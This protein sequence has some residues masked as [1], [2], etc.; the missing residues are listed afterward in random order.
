MVNIGKENCSD[1]ELTQNFCFSFINIL[2]SF[3]LLHVIRKTNH[4]H[5][6]NSAKKSFWYEL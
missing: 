2:R 4:D 5:D 6:D 1:A 3:L